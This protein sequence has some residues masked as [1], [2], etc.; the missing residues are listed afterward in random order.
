[1]DDAALKDAAASSAKATLNAFQNVGK[2]LLA[3]AGNFQASA[4]RAEAS[5]LLSEATNTTS[6][7]TRELADSGEVSQSE[8]AAIA[9]DAAS[10][11][12]QIV[13]NLGG[14]A[15]SAAKAAS[16]AANDAEVGAALGDAFTALGNTVASV[17]VLAGRTVSGAAGGDL[18]L[19]DVKLPG[20]LPKLP[21]LPGLP[22]QKKG[23]PSGFDE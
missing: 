11:T 13:S 18:K 20:G 7:L 19:P 8:A 9:R 3:F 17:G 2:S 6:A 16:N 12:G 10:S 14:A 22:G 15:S 1:L 5:K 23:P 21:D 4:D